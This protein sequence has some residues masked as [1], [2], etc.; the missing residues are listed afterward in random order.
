MCGGAPSQ[1]LL[2][3]FY[4]HFPNVEQIVS[5]RSKDKYELKVIEEGKI[6]SISGKS[7]PFGWFN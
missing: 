4:E 3:K 5:F 2:N 6:K 1:I 7:L